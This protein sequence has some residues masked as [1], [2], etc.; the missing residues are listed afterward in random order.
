MRQDSNPVLLTL[1]CVYSRMQGMS[2]TLDNSHDGDVSHDTV[3]KGK[4]SGFANNYLW[5]SKLFEGL[6]LP[7]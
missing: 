6:G 5:Q 1:C 2:H 3:H 7:K 4:E